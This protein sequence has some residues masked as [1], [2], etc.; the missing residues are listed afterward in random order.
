[1]RETGGDKWEKKGEGQGKRGE[2]RRGNGERT[3][4]RK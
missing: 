3:G 2:N 1:M 4:G